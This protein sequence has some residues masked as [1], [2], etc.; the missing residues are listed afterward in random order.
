[1]VNVESTRPD[2]STGEKLDNFRFQ[3][4]DGEVIQGLDFAVPLMF[5]GETAL[6]EVAPRFGYGSIGRQP[7]VKP[8]ETL[9]YRVELLSA[10]PER[11]MESYSVFER[12]KIGCVYSFKL[13]MIVEYPQGYFH[14]EYAQTL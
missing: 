8:D 2:G 10:E 12:S 3:I 14:T 9:F 7:D 1:M 13:P 11:D 6:L 4:G 5:V